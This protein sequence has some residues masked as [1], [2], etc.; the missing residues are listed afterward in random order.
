MNHVDFT[1]GKK[2]PNFKSG[3]SGDLVGTGQWLL[4]TVDLDIGGEEVGVVSS[5]VMIGREAEPRLMPEDFLRRRLDGDIWFLDRNLE[6]ETRTYVWFIM[7]C[8]VPHS[9]TPSTMSLSY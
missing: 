7:Q 9:Q 4:L 6:T 2:L 5:P 1:T 3:N 8:L